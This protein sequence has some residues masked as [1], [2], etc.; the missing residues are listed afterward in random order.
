MLATRR[1]PIESELRI[2]ATAAG[3]V[4]GLGEREPNFSLMNLAYYTF[5]PSVFRG[6]LCKNKN[7]IP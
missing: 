2:I 3:I 1:Q 4:K 5:E 6:A 7:A